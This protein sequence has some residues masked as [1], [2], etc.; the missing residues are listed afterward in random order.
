MKKIIK[1]QKKLINPTDVASVIASAATKISDG[2]Q[3]LVQDDYDSFYKNKN[4]KEKREI[5][6]YKLDE[7]YI[8]WKHT[9]ETIS[10]VKSNFVFILPEFITEKNMNDASIFVSG[11][12]KNQEIFIEFGPYTGNGKGNTYC[13]YYYNNGGGLRFSKTTFNYWKNNIVDDYIQ[14]KNNRNMTVECLL[15]DVAYDEYYT[16][17]DWRCYGKNG[18]YFVAQCIKA[19]KAKRYK[20]RDGRGIHALSISRIPVKILDALEE[21]EKDVRSFVGNIPV[22]GKFFDLG[23]AIGSLLD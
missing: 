22:I 4:F 7:V 21:N 5:Y 16:A 19:M 14:V 23:Q 18:N 8:G 17:N 20:G 1:A 11:E 2:I 3:G 13:H 9:F 10:E 15:D 6:D 12:Y